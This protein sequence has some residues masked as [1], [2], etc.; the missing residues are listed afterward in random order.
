MSAIKE[1]NESAAMRIL[2]ISTSG[3]ILVIISLLF[4]IF[5][6]S[7]QYLPQVSDDIEHILTDD[8]ICVT[9]SRE[10]ISDEK[11][12]DVNVSVRKEDK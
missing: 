3:I 4:M 1:P 12:I 6:S 2:I 10:A 5:L 8:A 7:C 11:N 9:V